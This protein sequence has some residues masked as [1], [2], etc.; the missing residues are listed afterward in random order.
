MELGIQIARGVVPEGRG[1]R[2]LVPGADHADG[3][4]VLQPGLG[5]VAL[6]PGQ[7]ALDRPVM[8]VD[9][10]PVAADQRRQRDGFWGREGEIPPGP[11]LQGPIGSPASEL[12]SGPV[13]YLALQHRLEEVR[14]DRTGE[15]EVLRALAGPG[16]RVPVGRV[17]PGV[18]AV[19]LVIGD[20]LGRG[21]DGADRDDHHSQSGGQRPSAPPAP[22]SSGLS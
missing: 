16:A 14:L 9:H 13:E 20:A 17:V 11:V 3:L 21:R 8:G 18:V 5:G 1:H 15:A 6:D 22:L 19:P 2:L 7:R 4:R 10:A 12:P